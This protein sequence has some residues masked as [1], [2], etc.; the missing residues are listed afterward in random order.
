M[1]HAYHYSKI[2]CYP[3]SKN[4]I[5]DRKFSKPRIGL[6]CCEWP[7]VVLMDVNDLIMHDGPNMVCGWNFI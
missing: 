2:A 7:M 4:L 3:F 1:I 5:K 6:N